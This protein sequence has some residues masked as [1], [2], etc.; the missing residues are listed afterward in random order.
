MCVRALGLTRGS[1]RGSSGSGWHGGNGL[2]GSRRGSRR[3]TLGKGRNPLLDPW[4]AA[5]GHWLLCWV[6]GL[7]AVCCS[8]L[9]RCL[10]RNTLKLWVL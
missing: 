4:I 9:A 8:G 1:G 10:S 7:E 3:G 5:Q 2:G 6:S